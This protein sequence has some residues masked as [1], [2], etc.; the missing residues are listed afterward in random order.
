MSTVVSKKIMQ[1]CP[2]TCLYRSD[3]GM[4][5]GREYPYGVKCG[6]YWVLRDAQGEVLSSNARASELAETYGLELLV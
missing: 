3:D 5:I 6:G 2:K 4:N 1:F